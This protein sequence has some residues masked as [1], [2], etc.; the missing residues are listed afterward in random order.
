MERLGGDQQPDLAE[1]L[2][3][4]RRMAAIEEERRAGEPFQLPAV[5]RPDKAST[6]PSA[7]PTL[8][9]KLSELL[10]K[11]GVPPVMPVQPQSKMAQEARAPHSWLSREDTTPSAAPRVDEPQP[12]GPPP[13][14]SPRFR[15]LTAEQELRNLNEDRFHQLVREVLFV[16]TSRIGPSPHGDAAL[17]NPY[18]KPPRQVPEQ[19]LAWNAMESLVAELLRPMLR[20]WLV[21]NMTVTVER[22]LSS[23]LGRMFGRG[24]GQPWTNSAFA[25]AAAQDRRAT[26]HYEP[27]FG[28]R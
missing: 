3:S 23:E 15:V 16:V 21:E 7:P 10:R 5:F 22:A 26:A 19:P 6:T 20:D 28:A 13:S 18:A 2:A 14:E 27:Y 8:A 1:V 12:A 11:T 24:G 9:D 25:S 4:I 17:R